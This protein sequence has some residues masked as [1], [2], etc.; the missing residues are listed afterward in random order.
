M[1]APPHEACGNHRKGLSVLEAVELF[2]TD[3]AAEAWFAECRWG[4]EPG[5]PSCGS[6]NVQ[7]GAK[8]PTMPYRCRSC[9][10]FFSVKT[11]TAMQ[12]S[13]LGLRAWAIAIYLMT[14][15]LRGRASIRLHRDLGITRKAAWHLAHRVHEAWDTGR[16]NPFERPVEVEVTYLGGLERNTRAAEKLKAGGGRPGN[17]TATG[18]RSQFADVTV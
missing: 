11:G 12:S 9:R 7:V 5:C 2:G 15:E 14:T 13:K 18:L 3:E 1:A 16:R 6:V 8:H 17:R 4:G 10:K